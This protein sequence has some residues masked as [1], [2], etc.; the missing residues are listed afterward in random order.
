MENPRYTAS[1]SRSSGRTGWSISFRHPLRMDSTGKPGLK[2][3]RGLGTA[4]DTEADRLVEEMNELLGD[5]RYWSVSSRP[6]AESRFSPPIVEAFYSGLEVPTSTP[7]Q[8]RD[9]AIPLPGRDDGYA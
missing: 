5:Q 4:D 7:I 3:R 1:K 8:V 9:E 2:M 6:Q